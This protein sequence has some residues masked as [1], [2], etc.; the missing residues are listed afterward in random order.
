M[1]GLTVGDTSVGQ[2][3]GQML[4]NPT[5]GANTIHFGDSTSGAAS[6]V[7]YINY[8]H[9][10]NSMQ[11]AAG[12]KHLNN[13]EVL[14]AAV[15]TCAVAT[16]GLLLA[17]ESVWQLFVSLCRRGDRWQGS[18]QTRWRLCSAAQTRPAVLALAV[19]V[20]HAAFTEPART[21]H[22]TAVSISLPFVSQFVYTGCCCWSI[23]GLLGGGNTRGM[24]RLVGWSFCN[25]SLAA[26]G[27]ICAIIAEHVRLREAFSGAGAPIVAYTV[28]RPLAGV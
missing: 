18:R 11:F 28:L 1:D 26:I 17:R 15:M 14:R 10:S 23:S 7:G 20:L 6:Y 4:A 8:A 13:A 3:L 9:D 19:G 16:F 25:T 5:N 27:V 21:A 24:R 12:A 22:S 2:S